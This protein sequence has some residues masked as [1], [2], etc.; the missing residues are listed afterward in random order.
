M[1]Y[2]FSFCSNI[3]CRNKKCFR[4]QNN[5]DLKGEHFVTIS[6]FPECEEFKKITYKDMKKLCN[7][8]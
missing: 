7:E 5:Y 8:I 2:D 1:I 6:N 3:E 4:N